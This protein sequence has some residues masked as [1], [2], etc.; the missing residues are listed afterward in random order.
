MSVDDV[1]V[2]SVTPDIGGLPR[3]AHDLILGAGNRLSKPGVDGIERMAE[4]SDGGRNAEFRADNISCVLAFGESR[5]EFDDRDAVQRVAHDVQCCAVKE[6]PI[7][8]SDE[9]TAK[10]D[11]CSL[12]T[13]WI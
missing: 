1:P 6:Y 8:V 12:T 3:N 4:R 2:P 11:Y 13:P 5:T 9:S 10:V 7:A